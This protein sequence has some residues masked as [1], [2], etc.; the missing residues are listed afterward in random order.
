MSIVATRLKR[1]KYAPLIADLSHRFRTYQ[2]S[3]EISVR[4]QITARNKARLKAFAYRVSTQPK[5]LFKSLVKNCSKI[6]LLS[7]LSIFSARSEP[8][9]TSPN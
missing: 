7:S 2:F 3:V 6:A 1:N 5:D 4:G 8:S 9:W